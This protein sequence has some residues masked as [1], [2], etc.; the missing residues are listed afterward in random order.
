[1]T[2]IRMARARWAILRRRS[3]AA[4][5]CA[6]VA[7]MATVVG[8]GSAS[9][10]TPVGSVVGWGVASSGVQAVPATFAGA[11]AIC[12]EGWSY[13]GAV[14]PSGSVVLWGQPSP[15][16][17]AVPSGLTGVVSLRCDATAVLALKADGTVV[18]WGDNASEVNVPAGLSGVKAVAAGSGGVPIPGMQRHGESDGGARPASRWRPMP[19]GQS[20]GPP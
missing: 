4:V 16:V 12:A 11:T 3:A 1:M 8:A 18:A 19:A 15:G 17:A 14:T 2:G 13:A 6:V 7:A 20:P 9:A 5:V 10:A